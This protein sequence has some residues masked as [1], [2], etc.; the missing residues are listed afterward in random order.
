M[1]EIKNKKQD[2]QTL[3]LY[4]QCLPHFSFINYTTLLILG[5]VL[6]SFSRFIQEGS[7]KASHMIFWTLPKGM[8][9]SNPVSPLCPL[10]HN[11]LQLTPLH[12]CCYSWS[13]YGAVI[14]NK[15]GLHLQ[16]GSTLTNTFSYTVF[17]V[18]SLNCFFIF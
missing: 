5:L 11:R 6:L 12:C 4:F 9:H 17:K 16:L 18:A 1:D 3:H 8:G 2:G 13:S 7:H 15:L 14:S 10:Y